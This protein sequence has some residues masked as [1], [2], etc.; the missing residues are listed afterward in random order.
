M[1]VLGWTVLVHIANVNA[2]N[3]IIL[4]VAVAGIF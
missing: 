1:I 2:V 3:L 4:I